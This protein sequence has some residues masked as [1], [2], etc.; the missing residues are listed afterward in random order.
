[1]EKMDRA[2]TAS[3]SS[4]TYSWPAGTVLEEAQEVE[5]ALPDSTTDTNSD[6]DI[7]VD[8]LN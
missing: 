5:S 6:S 2:P 8:R 1:M 3:F 7:T 4:G